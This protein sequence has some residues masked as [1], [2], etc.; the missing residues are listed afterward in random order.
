MQPF[1]PET[2]SL[3]AGFSVAVHGRMTPLCA[4]GPVFDPGRLAVNGNVTEIQKCFKS[5]IWQ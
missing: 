3:R 4:L 5:L 2:E 1:L